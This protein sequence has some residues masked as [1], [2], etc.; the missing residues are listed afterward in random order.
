MTAAALLGRRSQE[1]LARR[2]LNVIAGRDEDVVVVVA[3]EAAE[4]GAWHKV[5]GRPHVAAA[6]GHVV[7]RVENN[8]K[9]AVLMMKS[10]SL[11]VEPCFCSRR[12]NMKKYSA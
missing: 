10:T 4:H 5:C 2:H 1:D 7:V 11:M 12:C 6:S 3:L 9:L 8:G